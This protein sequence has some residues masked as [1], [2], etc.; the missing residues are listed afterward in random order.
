MI[1]GYKRVFPWGEPTYFREK[2]TLST[3]YTPGTLIHFDVSGGVYEADKVPMYPKIHTM[4][5]D[6]K[7]RWKHSNLIHHAYGTRTKSYDCFLQ[8]ECTGTQQT[9]IKYQG[10]FIT[11]RI[12]NKP[13]AK[14][15]LR[16][17]NYHYRDIELVNELARNDG[18]IDA[19][20]FF[21]WFKSDWSGKLIHW[22][23]KDY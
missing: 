8:M 18:F 3:F 15:P 9:E 17:T 16:A 20:Q 12:S 1:L 14:Y 11:I 10:D 22:T 4:R 23:S 7:D 21:R 13:Y 2:I 5:A 6:Q 19:A